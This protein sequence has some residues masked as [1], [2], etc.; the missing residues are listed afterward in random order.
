MKKLCSHGI[1]MFND[2]CLKCMNEGLQREATRGQK[3]NELTEELEKEKDRSDK[4]F[5]LMQER[6]AD[7]RTA[8]LQIIAL[9]NNLYQMLVDAW[10]NGFKEAFMPGSLDNPLSSPEIAKEY[11]KKIVSKI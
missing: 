10:N 3:I 4:F 6:N 9:K 2:K 1:D 8:E 11:A 7:A 5:K